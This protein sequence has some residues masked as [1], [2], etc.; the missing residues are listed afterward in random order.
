[1]ATVSY[2][3]DVPRSTSFAAAYSR[4]RGAARSQQ[5]R[6]DRRHA[7][8]MVLSRPSAETEV[9]TMATLARMTKRLFDDEC[10]ASMVEEALLLAVMVVAVMAGVMG[11]TN[12]LQSGILGMADVIGGTVSAP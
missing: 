8:C 11:I 2:R 1:V 4:L 12:T 7:R 9:F 3:D 10:G 6:I 5:A